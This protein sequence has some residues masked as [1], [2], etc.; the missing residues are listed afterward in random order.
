MKRVYLNMWILVLL[1][2]MLAA[3]GFAAAPIMAEVT[4]I[5]K[6]GN[7]VLSVTGGELFESG[8][9]YGDLLGVTIHDQAWLMPLCSNYSDVDTGTPVIRAEAEDTPAVI[10]IN[11]GDM[12]S[13]LGLAVK[14][15]IDE[16]P[17]YRW[18]LLD[19]EQ[20]LASIA[21]AEVGGYRVQWL[22]RQLERTNERSDYPHLSDDAF[23]NFRMLD[24]TG[25]APGRLYR[26]SSPINPELGR[27]V[28]ADRAAAAAGIACV[29]NLA[30]AGPDA[31]ERT[32]NA[33]YDTCDVIYLN[34]G[35]DFA[36]H[37]F[38]EGLARGLRFMMR[39]DGPYLVHCTEGK[40]RAGF[41]SAILECLMGASAAE[42][43]D[44]YMETYENYYGI[45]R[46]TEKYEAVVSSNIVNILCTAFEVEDLY[47]ADMVA[48]CEEF[49][50]AEL[51]MGLAEIELLKE[52]LSL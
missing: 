1:L 27:S 8:Y 3:N 47:A 7:L 22:L 26:S 12:A 40:D 35:V 42:V 33:Y 21:M 34:L 52:K 19:C 17:G 51:G 23:A 43:I 24:T 29:V 4:E 2:C 11:M 25:I 37:S 16:E 31:Y 48:E 45:K 20:I 15:S 50:Q 49:L 41:T 32:E 39:H 28:Y 44:D 36:S 10:A 6:Y 13:S 14:E 30:D 5:S 38:K 46:G 18:S 9:M